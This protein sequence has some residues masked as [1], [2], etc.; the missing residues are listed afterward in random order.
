MLFPK[1]IEKKSKIWLSKKYLFKVGAL[2]GMFK[3]VLKAVTH[4]RKCNKKLNKRPLFRKTD[5]SDKT[6][7]KIIKESQKFP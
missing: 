3:P 7:K 1:K 2:S 4:S 6:V 5:S